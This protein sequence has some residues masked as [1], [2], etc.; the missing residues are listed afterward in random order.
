[1]YITVRLKLNDG[2]LMNIKVDLPGDTR[3][4]DDSLSDA[5]GD[6]LDRMKV[7][8]KWYRVLKP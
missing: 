7:P 3:A 6:H 2:Q 4:D 8:Y 1:M 5:V